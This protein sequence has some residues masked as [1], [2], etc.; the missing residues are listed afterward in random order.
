MRMQVHGSLWICE[1]WCHPEFDNW[2]QC[3]WCHPE[4]VE[5]LQRGLRET[6]VAGCS[7]AI[8]LS[9]RRSVHRSVILCSTVWQFMFCRVTSKK[10]RAKKK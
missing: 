7:T 4:P 2:S 8:K 9:L 3:G 10:E 1:R 5:G 6:Y